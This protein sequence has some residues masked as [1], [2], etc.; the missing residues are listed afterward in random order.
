MS[1]IDKIPYFRN[2]SHYFLIKYET[3]AQR[4][5]LS[6]LVIKLV[7]KFEISDFH[8]EEKEAF[9][10]VRVMYNNHTLLVGDDATYEELVDEF[11]QYYGN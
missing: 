2:I 4:R 11:L 9:K 7:K 1:F 6:E 5:K 10:T 3:E 8:I